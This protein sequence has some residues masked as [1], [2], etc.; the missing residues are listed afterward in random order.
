M[1][2]QHIPLTFVLKLPRWE[3]DRLIVA[4]FPVCS[5]QH[6]A[7]ERNKKSLFIINQLL[8]T[9]QLMTT[10][11]VTM[12]QFVRKKG[13]FYAIFLVHII[14]QCYHLI[15]PLILKI[16]E[17]YFFWIL[18]LEEDQKLQIYSPTSKYWC[19]KTQPYTQRTETR[20][21]HS[22]Q[23]RILR[24]WVRSNRAA[25]WRIHSRASVTMIA[26]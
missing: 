4:F 17:Q 1:I 6:H 21:W 12:S 20:D 2:N 19:H 26:P 24:A 8:T 25:P 11:G 13:R 7:F 22:S 23:R 18:I 5:N 14:I 3:T 15:Y 16:L 10:H 9:E